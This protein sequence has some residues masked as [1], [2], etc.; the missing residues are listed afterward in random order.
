MGVEDRPGIVL[1]P[2][3][4]QFRLV[5]QNWS[6]RQ[7]P[8]RGKTRLRAM[9]GELQ[10]HTGN[11]TDPRIFLLLQ[12]WLKEQGRRWLVPRLESLSRETG[13][14]FT[15]SQIRLQ[16]SRWGSCSSRG[17]I[18]LN[19]AAMFVE[20]HL[21]D[22]LILHELCHTRHLNHSARFWNFLDSLAPGAR[23]LDK[24]LNMGW[25]DVPPWLYKR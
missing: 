20:P 7:L 10:I 8:S 24:A 25:R 5:D 21:V 17:L 2:T 1:L 6:V 12:D 13:L 3:Q 23:K 15:G 19:A 22:Y 16:R 9:P 11:A 14:T 4:V 18:S